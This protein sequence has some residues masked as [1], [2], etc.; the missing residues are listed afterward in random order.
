MLLSA[1]TLGASTTV[2]RH[3]QPND[4]P[5]QHPIADMMP[6]PSIERTGAATDADPESR[7][8][9]KTLPCRYCQKRFRRLEHVQRHERTHTKEKPFQCSCGKTFGRRDLL[10]RHEK[11]VHQNES[12]KESNHNHASNTRVS[13]ATKP[14]MS[15]P[16]V[17][18]I[19]NLIDPDLL[20][21]QNAGY[22]IPEIR[23]R[24]PDATMQQRLPCS[25]DLLSDAATHIASSNSQQLPNIIPQLM[26]TSQEYVESENKR[27]RTESFTG[28]GQDEGALKNSAYH[29]SGETGLLGDYNIF[30]D[31]CGISSH[32]FPPMDTDVPM[33]MWP[34]PQVASDQNYGYQQHQRQGSD[35]A[36]NNDHQQYGRY[37]PRMSS[38]MQADYQE[39]TNG[40][41]AIDDGRGGPP[42]KVSNQDHRYIQ[43][44][45][46]DFAS[47]LPKGFELPSRHTLSRF[48]EGYVNG[49]HEHVPFLHIPTVQLVN[50][51]PELLLAIAAIGA[52]YR[53]EG[54]R[55][56][57]LWYASRAVAMEQVRRRSSSQVMEIL[58]P[59]TTYRSDSA[60]LS[61]PS[62]ARNQN[63]ARSGMPRNGSDG[64]GQEF[65]SNTPEAKLETVQ[66]LLLLVA[67][68][69]FASRT[70][71][72]EAITIRS[73]L[74]QLTHDAG[75]TNPDTSRPDISWEDWIKAESEKRTKCLIYCFFNLHCITYDMPPLLVSTQVH[76]SL[77]QT[78]KEW[79]ASTAWEWAEIRR[80]TPPVEINFVDA[81][82]TLFA[83]P[84][85]V[86][87]KSLPPT[88]S[89]GNYM[90]ITAL[91]Q[92]VFFLR[93][94]TAISVPGIPTNGLRASDVEDVSNALKAWQA[95][96]ERTPESSLD[97]TGPNGPVAFNSTALLRFGFIRLHS[98]LGPSRFLETRDPMRIAQAFKDYPPV[99]RGPR[100]GR[101]VLQAAHALSIPIKI[102]VAFVAR[103]QTFS[104]SIQHSLCNLEC[105]F[106]LSKWL[107]TIALSPLDLTA[108][109]RNLLEMVRTMLDETEFAISFSG[110]QSPGQERQK[111]RKLS[112]AIVRL[113]AETF[114]GTQIFDIVK[115]MGS[116]L[117]IYANLLER[118]N[119]SAIG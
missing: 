35:A 113:W 100:I 79:K 76:I 8:K 5:A 105:A 39:T 7:Q 62:T 111:I 33:A 65:F 60:G 101:A 11:L 22:Q 84:G 81:L 27:A 70:L 56:N 23:N 59:P 69:T 99:A 116:S 88:S 28:R 86:L 77:P 40:A 19:P 15:P 45:V 57:G 93:Q 91:L 106:L 109:E 87:Q 92:H 83:K 78:T 53:F 2:S 73:F 66:A 26:Q 13:A 54:H 25:L 51:A 67:V 50:L 107:E 95:S 97:P 38:S 47:V 103:T 71:L 34:R 61:P 108:E 115:A 102:G 31:D 75:L 48:L 6:L 12:S 52:Q 41:R 37:V 94:T 1:G 32:V 24:A 118:S 72:R 9:A 58:S 30:L 10:V 20:A 49:F 114:K 110:T 74:A 43:S 82:T 119:D 85:S 98:D 80:Q 117:E 14:Q 3:H 112:V 42:W 68:G 63:A 104:W 96:W 4:T 46:E 55:G 36:Y 18:A 16:N 44:R 64:N 89:L 29:P 90:L 21:Q 17:A